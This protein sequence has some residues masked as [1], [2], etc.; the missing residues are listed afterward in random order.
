MGGLAV[1]RN[2]IALFSSEMSGGASKRS[3]ISHPHTMKCN[4]ASTVTIVLNKH[5]ALRR[6]P[7]EGEQIG[8]LNHSEHSALT[9]EHCMR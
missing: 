6:A 4:A 1:P 3:S 7:E 5:L 2:A 9:V 8:I